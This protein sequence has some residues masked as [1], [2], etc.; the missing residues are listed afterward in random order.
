M[1]V[2]AAGVDFAG[3]LGAGVCAGVGAGVCA[4][5]M[6]STI[7]ELHRTRI[8]VKLDARMRRAP[9]KILYQEVPR[10][11][12]E[13]GVVVLSEQKEVIDKAGEWNQKILD[14]ANK[15]RKNGFA[16]R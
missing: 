13:N 7:N 12:E 8:R 5:V 9:K 14:M 16:S 10:A 2:S 3:G 15:K 6:F 11:G 4:E 1:E